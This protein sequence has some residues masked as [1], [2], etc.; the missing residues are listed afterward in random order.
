MIIVNIFY[1]DR[2]LVRPIIAEH[3]E[4]EDPFTL[5]SRF[6]SEWKFALQ[7][8]RE[9]GEDNLTLDGVIELME[10]WG[11]TLHANMYPLVE[12]EY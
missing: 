3:R 2:E 6:E 5:I 9:G 10:K 11:W 4:T 1:A 12:V 8:I 7:C